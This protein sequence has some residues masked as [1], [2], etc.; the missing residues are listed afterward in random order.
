M[1]NY[2]F[3]GLCIIL[4]T[5][6]ILIGCIS[7]SGT[8]DNNV[9]SENKI[10]SELTS[11]NHSEVEGILVKVYVNKKDIIYGFEVSG[12]SGYAEYGRDII[13]AA[14]SIIAQNTVS[15]IKIYTKDKVND[16]ID[17]G[18]LKCVLPNMKNGEGSKEACVLLKSAVAG[19]YSIQNSYDEKYIKVFK[20]VD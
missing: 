19:F 12:H 3:S 9:T 17:E 2:K 16:N 14:A 5:L 8:V 7:N 18:Y 11:Y 10:L 1:R 15:S 4:F 20:V 13:C 6:I